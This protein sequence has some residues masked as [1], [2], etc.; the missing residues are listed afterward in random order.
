MDGA[1]VELAL[2]IIASRNVKHLFAP[3]T[4]FPFVSDLPEKKA[5]PN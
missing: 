1:D 5:L 4:I 2:M 3:V